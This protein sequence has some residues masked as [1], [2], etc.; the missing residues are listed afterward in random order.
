MAGI[1]SLL[2][3]GTLK[4]FPSIQ[5]NL[6]VNAFLLSVV[7]QRDVSK[8]SKGQLLDSVLESSKF[9]DLRLVFQNS[10]QT[11]NCSFAQQRLYSIVISGKVAHSFKQV[12]KV[13]TVFFLDVSAISK[14]NEIVV[15]RG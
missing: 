12:D 11:L 15:D 5:N 9:Q 7:I 8:N 1:E 13:F 6:V 14:V 10:I 2:E 3:I 4:E